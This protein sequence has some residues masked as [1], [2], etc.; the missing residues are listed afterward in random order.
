MVIVRLRYNKVDFKDGSYREFRDWGR[1]GSGNGEGESERE[2]GRTC[3]ICDSHAESVR[4]GSKCEGNEKD[5]RAGMWE[6][7][8]EI[9]DL[10]LPQLGV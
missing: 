2:Y 6:R 8:E 5:F 9:V 4:K 3:L 10:R 1:S 7:V